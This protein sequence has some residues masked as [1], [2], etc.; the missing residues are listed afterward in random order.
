MPGK[1]TKAKKPAHVRAVAPRILAAWPVLGEMHRE[2]FR[3]LATTADCEALGA[4]TDSAAVLK[5]AQ[6]WAQAI[7]AALRAHPFELRRYG[8]PR[9]VWFVEC[10]RALEDAIESQRGDNGHG[11]K[12]HVERAL[13][14]A[15]EVQADL[16]TALEVV[17]QGRPDAERRL[18]DASKDVTSAAGLASGLRALADL[19]DELGRAYDPRT[20]A[21]VA[22]VTLRAE[23]AHAARDAAAALEVATRAPA[24]G[25]AP[26]S[27]LPTTD[28]V[29]GRV[30]YEMRFAKQIFDRVRARSPYIPALVP[31][32]GTRG[33]LGARGA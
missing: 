32:T 22:S 17:A 1:R 11:H 27:D 33:V 30:V 21:L 12:R 25:G 4:R 16:V 14:R 18:A 31:G 2:A 23:D 5:D 9:F 24:P 20:R 29:E 3:S 6:A 8:A 7:D 10:V 26:L 28:R 19:A 13:A 15:R